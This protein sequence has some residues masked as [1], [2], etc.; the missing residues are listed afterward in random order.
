MIDTDVSDID[1]TSGIVAYAGSNPRLMV[2]AGPFR[3]GDVVLLDMNKFSKEEQKYLKGGRR[4][5]VTHDPVEGE[6]VLSEATTQGTLAGQGLPGLQVQLS[7]PKAAYAGFD[8]PLATIHPALFQTFELSSVLGKVGSLGDVDWLAFLAALDAGL[9][10]GTGRVG[11]PGPGTNSASRRGTIWRQRVGQ[12]DDLAIVS[13]H[14]Y[15]TTDSGPLPVVP[16]DTKDNITKPLAHGIL[17]AD[18][19]GQEYWAYPSDIYLAKTGIPGTNNNW[20][21]PGEKDCLTEESMQALDGALFDWLDLQQNP[22]LARPELG[23]RGYSM[24]QAN[25]QEAMNSSRRFKPV[26]PSVNSSKRTKR[27]P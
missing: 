18:E 25:A 7:A 1:R 4:W 27:K 12:G 6:I 16:L 10:I 23:K 2:R 21:K 22:A 13:C 14:A 8:E 24:R 26:P 17:V 20:I 11:S 5:V 9:G 15:S 19:N 3:S